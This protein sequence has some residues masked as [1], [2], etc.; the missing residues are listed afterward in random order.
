[1]SRNRPLQHLNGL[2]PTQL[3]DLLERR[4]PGP[5]RALPVNI[6]RVTPTRL[7]R[8]MPGD[9]GRGEAGH[10]RVM[11]GVSPCRVMP[12]VS[13]CRVM[14]ESGHC[15]VMPD[16]G[17]CRIVE[18]DTSLGDGVSP[19]RVVHQDANR[20]TAGCCR[21]MPTAGTAGSA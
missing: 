9:A 2:T 6:C 16:G 8:V 13:P 12:D 19:C 15:R 4:H 5:G 17:F 18:A 21:V 20:G 11:P 3:Q 7:G 1:M 14:P 10:C